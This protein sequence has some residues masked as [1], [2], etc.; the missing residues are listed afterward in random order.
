MEN[1]MIP[2]HDY[3][4]IMQDRTKKI[5]LHSSYTTKTDKTLAKRIIS[6]LEKSHP[7]NKYRLYEYKGNIRAKIARLNKKKK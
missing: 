1:N 2:P 3:H 7:G 5:Y 6:A 4:I